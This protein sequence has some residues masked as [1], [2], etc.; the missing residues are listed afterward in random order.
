MKLSKRRIA[1]AGVTLLSILLAGAAL[2]AR[3]TWTRPE[4]V[5]SKIH[6][7]ASW[8][9]SRDEPM[10]AWFGTLKA[11]ESLSGPFGRAALDFALVTKEDAELPIYSAGVHQ[12][13]QRFM[14][15]SVVV[16]GKLIDLSDEGFGQELWI[17]SIGLVAAPDKVGK[18]VCDKKSSAK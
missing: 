15:Q 4:T 8:Y 12:E 17:G 5:M 10:R 7:E 16:C 6:E 18:E 14:D 11:R 9:A 1:G 2:G 13:L 3:G